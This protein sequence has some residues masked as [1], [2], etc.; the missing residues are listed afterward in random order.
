MQNGQIQFV[1]G[2]WAQIDYASIDFISALES[3]EVGSKFLSQE[4]G[5]QPE[6]LHVAWN[7][8]SIGLTSW[9]PDLLTLLG[10]DSLF[11]TMLSQHKSLIDN[12]ELQFIW[13]SQYDSSDIL[14]Q[15][16]QS[17]M[18][19]PLINTFP[20]ELVYKV[21]RPKTPINHCDL[22]LFKTFNSK[23]IPSSAQGTEPALKCLDQFFR[24]Y[25]STYV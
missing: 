18:M 2:A 7:D 19:G 3:I 15:V 1:G 9:T 24:D 22:A 25:I 4:F 23:W 13:E 12:G 21:I 20:W 16:S 5:V 14:V 8:D 11:T 10:Y 6:D 17:G